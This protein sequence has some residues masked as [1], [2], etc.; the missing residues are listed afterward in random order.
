LQWNNYLKRWIYWKKKSRPYVMAGVRLG[1]QTGA[2]VPAYT[3]VAGATSK[4]QVSFDLG[5]GMEWKIKG[6][7]NI[8]VEEHYNPDV[9]PAY[10]KDKVAMWHRTW[11]TRIGIM[12]RFKSGIGAV[13]L[14]CNAPRYHGR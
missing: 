7:W 5:V 6:P 9:I 14:D 2:A 10:A 13:D 8:F 3:Y 11:E 1:M 12:Y 4:F